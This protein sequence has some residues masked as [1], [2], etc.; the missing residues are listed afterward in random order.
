MIPHILNNYAY[1]AASILKNGWSIK[2]TLVCRNIHQAYTVVLKQSLSN[3]L[4]SKAP[5][6]LDRFAHGLNL[7]DFDVSYMRLD[8]VLFREGFMK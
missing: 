1:Y 7:T 3:D 8:E 4:I 2:V 6:K 5:I